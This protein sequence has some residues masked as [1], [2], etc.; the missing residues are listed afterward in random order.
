MRQDRFFENKFDVKDWLALYEEAPWSASL[1]SDAI[2]PK[3]LKVQN[4]RFE[5]AIDLARKKQGIRDEENRIAKEI[6]DKKDAIAQAKLDK[7][8]K[9]QA[10]MVNNYGEVLAEL[11]TEMSEE[12]RNK[13]EADRRAN[14]TRFERLKEDVNMF[15]NGAQIR[16]EQEMKRIKASI[17][18]KQRGNLGYIEGIEQIQIRWGKENN[19]E[20]QELQ[21]E[22]A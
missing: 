1:G 2:E 5:K 19:K 12:L 8:Q 21:D 9:E 4:K 22:F 11:L 7:K 6:Q 10:D 15:F 13:K 3:I 20:F 16:E 18:N 14:K 17:R